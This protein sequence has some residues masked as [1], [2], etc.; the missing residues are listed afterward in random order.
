MLSGKSR[1]LC[2]VLA[3]LVLFSYAAFPAF[4]SGGLAL[5]GCESAYQKP[6][7]TPVSHDSTVPVT[8][9]YDYSD[10][11]SY[12]LYFGQLSSHSKQS[13]G[14]ASLDEAFIHARDTAKLDFF[15]VTDNS[16]MFDNGTNATLANGNTS[17]EWITG[18]A[19]AEYYTSSKFVGIY[20]Y[21]MTWSNGS[22]HINTYN[23]EGFETSAESAYSGSNGLLN[24]YNALKQYPSSL[25]QFNHP[26][27]KYGDFLD[28][29][30][31]DPQIDTL[32][33]LIEVGN[34]EGKVGSSLYFP[35]YDDYTRALDT[36]WHLAPTNNQD[37]R[38]GLFG[39]ANT[40]R[41]VVLS[42]NLKKDEIFNAIRNRRVYA[43][44]DKDLKIRY[45]LNGQI[46]GS[47]INTK[48]ANVNIR[49]DLVEP[50]GE[51][52]G[53]VSVIANGGKVVNSQTL[54]VSSY[55]LNLTLPPDNTYYYIRVDQFDKDI[56]VT[57]P[58]WIVTD[59][60]TGNTGISKTYLSTDSP[61]KGEAL[62]INTDVYNGEPSDMVLSS[63][64]FYENNKVIK[65]VESPGT[66]KPGTTSEFIVD[67]TPPSAGK[68]RIGILLKATIN[69]VEKVYTDE[70]TLD[71]VNPNKPDKPDKHDKDKDKPDAVKAVVNLIDKIKPH[72][73]MLPVDSVKSARNAYNSLTADQKKL[74]TNYDKLLAAEQ[75]VQWMDKWGKYWGHFHGK[76]T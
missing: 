67:Y 72:G 7:V 31:C 58:V 5:I 42:K 65:T 22:G 60:K 16:D 29:G 14:T 39:D 49:V 11:N 53:M 38:Q 68:I 35:S 46:M 10:V 15:A 50:D 27:T 13:D 56:A 26:G 34:G 75:W 33:S 64:I 61:K 32:I 18:K 40:A 52:I 74:V 9:V 3:I 48:P 55:T 69:G 21:E 43:T 66:V 8:P 20:G 36:G 41:T 62:K 73:Y 37:N 45:S 44:E 25:S 24:Y 51:S 59:N 57:A 30:Y 76:K 54:A 2:F 19:A 70:I 17:S 28:F 71:A 12:N 4:A 63:L 47:I 1:I 23:T 6:K